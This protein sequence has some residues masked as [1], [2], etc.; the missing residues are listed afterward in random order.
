MVTSADAITVVTSS[1]T[2][3][4]LRAALSRSLHGT[5]ADTFL[6][7]VA[8]QIDTLYIAFD[9]AQ[10]AGHYHV[11]GVYGSKYQGVTRFLR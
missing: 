3:G 2:C 1:T 5:P 9:T 7:V 6:S 10:R 11:F 8:V 4:H